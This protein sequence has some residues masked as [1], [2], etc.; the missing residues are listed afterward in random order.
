M[1]KVSYRILIEISLFNIDKR[2]RSI[3]KDLN[4]RYIVAI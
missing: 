4:K 1:S 2:L 3:S